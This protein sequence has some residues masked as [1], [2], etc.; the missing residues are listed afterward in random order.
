MDQLDFHKNSTFNAPPLPIVI[1]KEKEAYQYWQALHRNFPKTERFSIGQKISQTFIEVLE[2][3]F[4]AS[5]LAPEQKIILLTKTSSRLDVLKF[6][7]QLT[8]ESKLIP[9]EK[10]IELSKKLE[11]IGRMLGGWR[12]GLLQKKTLTR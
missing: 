1:N 4:T 9:T 6:F 8:W 11:E 7:V 5:Y 10:Y 12:K 2:L 3:N